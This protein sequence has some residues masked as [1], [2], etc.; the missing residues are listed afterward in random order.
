MIV[1][2]HVH[3]WEV[4]PPKYPVGPTAPNTDWPVTEA[5]KT[6]ELIEEMDEHGVDWSVIVQSS[7]STWDNGYIADSAARFPDRLL[8]HGLVDPKDAEN[9]NTARY[10]MQERGLVGFRMHPMYYPDEKV[11]IDP[12]N[13]ALWE[14]FAAAG[15]IIQLHTRPE[16]ADQIDE[17]A[18]RHPDLTLIIDHLGYPEIDQDPANFQ[19]IIDLAKRAN[20]FLKL[21]DVKGR[22]NLEFPF[23]D[24]HP[25]IQR[26]L[27]GFGTDRTMW[28]TGYPGHHRA[29]HN[30]LTLDREL[31]LVRDGFP[32]LSASDKDRILGGTGGQ[33][34][35]LNG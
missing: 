8:G 15:A 9:A 24:V 3:V 28:G 2:T 22:S 35:G 10:W 29:A 20:M 16:F 18:Q 19:P 7:T 11:L 25:F 32:F 17:I 1:D 33:I 6:E 14:E 5:G 26:L 31:D 27:D 21:S 30:W 13:K 23:E 34:W 4:D 12:Q